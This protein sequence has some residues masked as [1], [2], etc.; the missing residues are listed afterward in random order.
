MG[1][2]PFELFVHFWRQS[3]DDLPGFSD[4]ELDELYEQ[5]ER[6]EAEKR[7]IEEGLETT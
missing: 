4:E 2:I 7:T 5:T 3:T 1:D 6:T